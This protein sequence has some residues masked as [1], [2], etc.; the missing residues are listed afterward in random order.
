M[1]IRR[2]VP[3]LAIVATAC[4]HAASPSVA[5]D[6]SPSSVSVPM[7]ASPSATAARPSG[8]A[9]PFG[10]D[11]AAGDVDLAD[12]V[13]AGTDPAGSW[14]ATT[15]DG[16]AIV[17]AWEA[18]GGDPFRTDRGFVVWRLTGD[19][20]LWRPVDAVTYPAPRHPVLGITA[21]IGDMTGDGSDDALVF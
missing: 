4:A 16:D 12:L 10:E 7:P 9:S 19:P 2:L 15:F 3:I 18:P 6:P 20:T 21:T 1:P 11:V 5:P 14:Y 13:P 17:V 8:L